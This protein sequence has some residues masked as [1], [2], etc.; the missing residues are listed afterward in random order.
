MDIKYIIDLYNP[1]SRDNNVK[2]I[3]TLN[4]RQ[5]CIREVECKNG[6]PLLPILISEDAPEPTDFKLFKT[7]EA[8]LYYVNQLIKI[9]RG[10]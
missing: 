1:Y 7:Y 10:L 8:A 2:K 4:Q 5:W 3:F 6:L 9:N